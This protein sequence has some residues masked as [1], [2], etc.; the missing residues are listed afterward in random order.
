[1]DPLNSVEL[2]KALKEIW[3][4]ATDLA[5]KGCIDGL[6]VCPAVWALR[7]QLF[8]AALDCPESNFVLVC[9][10]F[11]AMVI[12]RYMHLVPNPD[13]F[14]ADL[15]IGRNQVV[16][17]LLYGD[18]T[19]P[20]LPEFTPRLGFATSFDFGFRRVE[21]YIPKVPAGI[22]ERFMSLCLSYDLKPPTVNK[23]YTAYDPDSFVLTG[24]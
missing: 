13:G 4:Q 17:V 6:E 8:Q 1:V 9:Y 7:E 11:G 12:Q 23:P 10:S 14:D 5:G 20:Q 15:T 19:W 18:P 16:A 21:D 22:D 2:L 3:A 24:P